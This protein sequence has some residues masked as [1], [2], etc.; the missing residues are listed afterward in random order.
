M[1]GFGGTRRKNWLLR[2]DEPKKSKKTE[3]GGGGGG[4]KM[5]RQKRGK[6]AGVTYFEAERFLNYWSQHSSGSTGGMFFHDY[7]KIRLLSDVSA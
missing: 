5:I 1:V 6:I 4:C 7:Q 2:E 3:D